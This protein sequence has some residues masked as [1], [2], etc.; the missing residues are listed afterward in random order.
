MPARSISRCDT[1][2]A[3]FGFSFKIGRKNRDNRIGHTRRIGEECSSES[4]LTQKTQGRDLG[5]AA[6]SPDFLPLYQ[7]V[8]KRKRLTR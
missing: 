3:S 7:L 5:K 6:K 8:D 4:G 2:S 1:I